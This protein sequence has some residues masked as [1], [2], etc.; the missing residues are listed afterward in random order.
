MK[1]RLLAAVRRAVAPRA[2]FATSDV[3]VGKDV[4]FGRNVRF[5]SRTVRIGDGCRF[6]DDVVVNSDV[7]ELG[8]YGTVYD[9]CFFPGPG[10]L[11]IGHNFWLGTGSIVDA[12]GG[13]RIGDNVG[14]GAYSQLWGHMKYGDTLVGCRF[15]TS[16]ALTIGDDVWLV[17]HVLVSPVTVGDRALVMLGSMVTRDIEADR[18]YA[19]SPAKDVTDRFGTQFGEVS[20]A[21]RV[22]ELRRRIEGFARERGGDAGQFEVVAGDLGARAGR[23]VFDV[24]SRR[25]TKRNVDS[26]RALMRWLLP[27]AKFVPAT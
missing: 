17:G 25:Y 15:H 16:R 7:F 5:T 26:E 21:D 9:R 23:T 1:E 19:G 8:D 13:T 24:V 20:A 12:H 27:D 14:I 18:T 22:V 2:R 3:R 10:E 6:G 11:R 4:T